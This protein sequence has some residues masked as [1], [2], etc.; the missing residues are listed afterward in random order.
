ML[1]LQVSDVQLQRHGA[2]RVGGLIGAVI[3]EQRVVRSVRAEVCSDCTSDAHRG[4]I[5]ES[6]GLCIIG[7]HLGV[8]QIG[9]TN[10]HAFASHC[11]S[12][13]PPY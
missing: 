13:F 3:S 2:Q 11:H 12:V 7:Q 1:R 8:V 9:Q 4:S 10:S 5:G 6:P